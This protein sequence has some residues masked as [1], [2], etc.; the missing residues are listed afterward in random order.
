LE[1]SN[2]CLDLI[3]LSVAIFAKEL[4]FYFPP[5]ETPPPPKI[6]I[7]DFIRDLA[8]KV[9]IFDFYEPVLLFM[10]NLNF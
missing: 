2:N 7:L 8:N 4:I 10:K 6:P 9:E 5:P 1:F 3:F